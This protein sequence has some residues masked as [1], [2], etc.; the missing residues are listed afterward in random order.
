MSAIGAEAPLTGPACPVQPE[1]HWQAV[2]Q[3]KASSELTWYQREAR[4]SLEII[5]RVLPERAAPILDVGGGTSTL[6]DGLLDAGYR[7]VTILDVAPAALAAVRAR[8]GSRAELVRWLEADVLRA[9]LPEAGYALWHDRA[10]FHFL[11]EARDRRLYVEQARRALRPRGFLLL[12]AF[13]E[14]GPSQCSGLPVRRYRPETLHAEVGPEFSLLESVYEEHVTPRG[15]R[16]PF[17][18]CVFEL[19]G[20]PRP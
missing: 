13:G 17:V 8:L 2:Y 3:A 5:E 10:L 18:Y 1:A 19:R 12:A 9:E 7:D 11:T 20:L 14:A 15:R 6:V 4:A 16:Q